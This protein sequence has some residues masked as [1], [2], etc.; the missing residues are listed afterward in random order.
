MAAVLMP[1]LLPP[2]QA[3]GT[4]AKKKIRTEIQV[5]PIEEFKVFGS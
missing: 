3:Q 5:L 1:G 4:G 2:P